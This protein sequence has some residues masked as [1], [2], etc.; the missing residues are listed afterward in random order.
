MGILEDKQDEANECCWWLLFF[1]LLL[2]ISE[3]F[4]SRYLPFLMRKLFF[5][6]IPKIIIFFQLWRTL[7]LILYSTI[8]CNILAIMLHYL[9]NSQKY[10][11]ISPFFCYV[12]IF[13]SNIKYALIYLFFSFFFSLFFS[14]ISTLL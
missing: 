6:C 12:W 10:F 14:T 13:L 3:I 8:N 11:I 9:I 4:T 5:F 7:H 2:F 1:K